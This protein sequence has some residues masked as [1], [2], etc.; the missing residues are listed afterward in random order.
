MPQAD[1]PRVS[2]SKEGVRNMQEQ[3][4][5]ARP[6]PVQRPPMQVPA[7]LRPSNQPPSPPPP[8]VQPVRVEPKVLP[9]DPCPC[10]S[11]LKYKKCHGA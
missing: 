1:A 8:K 7:G 9:N 10:G 5:A 3:L 11:G 2:A 4:A 6:Q